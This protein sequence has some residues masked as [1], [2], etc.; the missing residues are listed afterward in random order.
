MPR[1]LNQTIERSAEKTPKKTALIYKKEALS[2]IQLNE[3]IPTITQG[4]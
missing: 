3:K 2:Y 4:Q 1:L